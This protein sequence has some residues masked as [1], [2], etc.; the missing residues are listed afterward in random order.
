ME[1]KVML[2]AFYNYK[3]AGVRILERALRDRGFEVVTV[4]F[5]AFNSVSPRPAAPAELELLSGLVQKHRPL[6][7]GLS[8]MSSM[9]LETVC[10]VL[11]ALKK[12]HRSARSL[13]RRAS[14]PLSRAAAPSG[15]GFCAADGRRA[16]YLPAC[17]GDLGGRRFTV[18]PFSLL[19][20]K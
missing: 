1:K 4:F 3:A 2:V 10:Q 7:V 16:L 19:L 20:E 18:H 14:H 17:A 6:L 5:K 11:H 12:K 15:R 9:Y 8:V 13:R